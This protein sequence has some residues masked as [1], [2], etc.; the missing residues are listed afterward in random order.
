MF[1]ISACSA[2]FLVPMEVIDRAEKKLLL[3]G[4]VHTTVSANSLQIKISTLLCSFFPSRS[5]V[6]PLGS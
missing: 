2:Y 6:P 5:S 1:Q 3:P 4:T